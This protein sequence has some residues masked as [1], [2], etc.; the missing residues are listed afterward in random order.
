LAQLFYNFPWG[1]EA[2]AYI[3]ISENIFRDVSATYTSFDFVSD[4]A[5]IESAMSDA[6]T[7]RLD[8]FGAVL[9]TF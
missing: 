1:G 6:L 4:R 3:S 8:T 5:D 9:S 2:D 7:D